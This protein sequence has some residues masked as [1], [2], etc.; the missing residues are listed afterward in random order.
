MPVDWPHGVTFPKP[1]ET[2]AALWMPQP[3]PAILGALWHPH[4]PVYLVPAEH[5]L[6]LQCFDG[7]VF[8]R[9]LELDQEDLGPETG[10][11]RVGRTREPLPP[12]QIRSS[13][14]M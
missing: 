11:V 12:T 10:W 2:S 3:R 8:P 14:L 9:P 1:Q 13:R 7:V 4:T 5:L 6:L